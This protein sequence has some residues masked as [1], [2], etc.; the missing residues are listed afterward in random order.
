MW[1][2]NSPT[3][4]TSLINGSTEPSAPYHGTHNDGPDSFSDRTCRFCLERDE[5]DTMI[6]PCLCTGTMRWVH[7]EC[8]DRWRAVGGERSFTKCTEC[9]FDYQFEVFMPHDESKISAAKTKFRLFVARD[10]LLIFLIIQIFIA[11]LGYMTAEIDGDHGSHLRNLFPEIISSHYKTTYYLCGLVLFLALIG[12][13]GSLLYCISKVNTDDSDQNRSD[14]SSMCDCVFDMC[15]PSRRTQRHHPNRR[16]RRRP[17]SGEYRAQ[18]TTTSSTH[19]CCADCHGVNCD[20]CC[21]SCGNDC[22]CNCSGGGGGGGGNDGGALVFVL[23][24]VF[25]FA[26]IGILVGLFA[27]SILIQKII[28]R[29]FEIVERS[30]M[31]QQYL[32]KDL[33]DV[34]DVELQ[35]RMSVQPS[36][37]PL[38]A[39]W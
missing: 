23:V 30:C 39:T 10:T 5:P 19:F 26:V 25:V 32:V 34:P 9:N 37:P 29:H 31:T 22:D 18:T 2:S 38:P 7:R 4:Q 16:M 20:C 6:K 28:Q 8:L 36:A 1:S 24:I 35:Q 11:L 3:E 12:L 27:G 17:G 21:D 15:Y 13:V 33:A 14:S